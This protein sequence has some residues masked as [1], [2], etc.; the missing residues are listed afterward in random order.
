MEGLSYQSLGA[1]EWIFGHTNIHD[2]SHNLFNFF[3]NIGFKG[4]A[5]G[6][7]N[8]DSDINL[9]TNFE[10]EYVNT[11][12]S[13]NFAPY[14]H[15]IAHCRKFDTPVHWQNS[16]PYQTLSKRS[17]KIISVSAD[18]GIK[19]G[20]GI[21]IST[22]KGRG[23]ISLDFDGSAEAFNNYLDKEL[24][25][26]IGYCQAVM[27]KAANEFSSSIF[28]QPKLT[29]K[30]Y[31]CINYMSQG[32]SNPEIARLLSVS[33]NRIKEL[34]ASLLNKLQAANRTEAVMQALQQGIISF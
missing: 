10:S 21:P 8:Q 22:L 18:Y 32:L 31:E 5:I 26:I 23:M 9:V 12:M 28:N 6:G 20:I 29:P 27:W 13:E 4:V 25:S 1:M 30:E 19:H 34:V 15:V 2:F 14:D 33:V 7:V 16:Y 11:Y 3:K 17:Q 24:F